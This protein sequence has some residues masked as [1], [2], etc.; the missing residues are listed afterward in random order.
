[1]FS[2]DVFV[3]GS[4]EFPSFLELYTEVYW[5]NFQGSI[6]A[7]IGGNVEGAQKVG[8]RRMIEK[9]VAKPGPLKIPNIVIGFKLRDPALGEKQLK[10]LDPFKEMAKKMLP[11]PLAERMTDVKIGNG[12]FTKISLDGGL[13]PWDQFPDDG[14][15]LE[16]PQELVKKL[17]EK[18][19]PTTLQLALGMRDN[20]LLLSIGGDTSTLEMLGNVPSLLDRPECKVLEKKMVDAKKL[21]EISYV[22]KEM[23]RLS[24]NT[25]EDVF[26]GIDWITKQMADVPFIPASLRDRVSKDLKA[27]GND[28][29]PH[30]SEPGASLQYSILTSRGQET[31][32]YSWTTRPGLDGSKPLTIAEHLGGDPIF[33]T[34]T[35][36]K[37]SAAC[38]NLMTKQAKTLF[39]Y[40]ND[41]GLGFLPEDAKKTYD[42]I[43]KLA[44]PFLARFDEITTTLL[45]PSLDEQGA[46]VI[47]AKL[48][49]ARWHEILKPSATPL[50]MLE[51]ACLLG[52]SDS[53]KFVKAFREYG[54]AVNTLLRETAK[55]SG[56]LTPAFKIP[57]PT[58]I[59]LQSG[60]LYTYPLPGEL[61]LDPQLKPNA[62]VG[63][64]LALFSLSEAHSKKLLSRTPF[65]ATTSPLARLDQ[66][67][68]S[69]TYVNWVGFADAVRPW[70]HYGMQ[71]STSPPEE[72]KLF[73]E[74]IELI[75]DLIKV[76]QS[77]SSVTYQEGGAWV[78]HSEL[79]IK[80]VE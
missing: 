37:G 8:L 28:L 18:I 26:G 44:F 21:L 74:Q 66:P 35:R 30:L 47:D 63:K 29:V 23:Y 52:V 7:A 14:G 72:K 48:K 41:F 57:L 38:Y 39:G 4:E 59:D 31:F 60:M 16:L 64:N 53:D 46:C 36:S 73:T 2:D 3:L 67:A 71:F 56:G 43:T 32:H 10:K 1:M 15:P 69:M 22:S 75:F 54:E 27:L 76:V 50:P 24:T 79:I 6:E 62:S 80:D 58:Q 61:G 20:Y 5:A 65:K 77:Y 13:F 12:S 42:D 51:F 19:R 70:A 33:A 17:Q 25:K 9:L 55:E 68:A 78:T 49:S 45:L 40:W 34:A 11:P